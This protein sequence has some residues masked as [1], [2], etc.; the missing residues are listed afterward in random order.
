[1][2]MQ[3][4]LEE[5]YV[6]DKKSRKEKVVIALSG[7]LD[8]YVMAY[9]LK[10]QKYELIGVTVINSWDN[11]SGDAGQILSCHLGQEKLNEIK[12]FCHKLGISHHVIKELSQFKEEVV[13]SWMADKV[14]GKYPTPCWNCHELRMKILHQAMVDMGAKHLATGHFAKIFHNESHGSVFVHTSN[15]EDNDQASFLSRLPHDVLNS[16]ILP[17]SDLTKKEVIKLAE[18]FGLIEHE[19]KIKVHQCFK[20]NDE[21]EKIF[22]TKIPKKFRKE[23]DITGPDKLVSYGQHNGVH[24]HSVGE[25]FHLREQGRQVNGYFGE[26]SYLDKRIVV[27]K[28]DFFM[29]DRLLLIN[30]RF[31]EEVSWLGP[32]KGFLLIDGKTFLDCWIHPKTLSTV[33]LELSEEHKFINGMVLAVLKKKGKN[34]KV[35]LTGEVQ[36]LPPTPVDED[37]N[38][39][40]PKI[41]Y[42]IDF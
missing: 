40:I 38:K 8:S 14:L 18:N 33:Y 5:A 37:G 10:I 42:G 4:K 16:L 3:K 32:I 35:Y 29:R 20:W 6:P 28:E 11:Y 36:L 9:L 22:E 39:D 21:I 27:V 12:D 24:F 26:F 41:N 34:S 19:S 1:M 31:S 17:L 2:D 25:S 15:D 7:G 30:C 23:G 13:E